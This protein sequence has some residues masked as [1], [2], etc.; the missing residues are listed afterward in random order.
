MNADGFLDVLVPNELG[1]TASYWI[2]P[3]RSVFDFSSKVNRQVV[4]TSGYKVNDVRAR[5]FTGDGHA[6]IITANWSSSTISLFPGRGDGTFGDERLMSSGKHCVFFAVGDFDRDS[7]LDFTVTHWTEDFL[8]VF[9]NDGQGHFPPQTDYKTGLGNYGVLA[10][11][12]DGDGR[13]D[14]VTANYRDHSTSLLVGRGDGT[15]A[16][17]VTTR[18]SFR[19]TTD[20]FVLER[21][22]R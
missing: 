20:G 7:D 5:D 15:F 8:S 22:S 16:P 13:L 18:R 12:A 14:L 10:F 1:S 2:S 6:D 21:P 4:Q 17:A 3:E 9:L 19:Q 11:D